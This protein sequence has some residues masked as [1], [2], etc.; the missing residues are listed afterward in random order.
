MDRILN[1]AAKFRWTPGGQAGRP[2]VFRAAHGAGVGACL[3]H[4]RS[5]RAW[6]LNVP[7]LI[8]SMPSAVNPAPGRSRE[9]EDP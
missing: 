7:G 5:P 2:V 1:G 9:G 8:V 4:S 6:F 3:H